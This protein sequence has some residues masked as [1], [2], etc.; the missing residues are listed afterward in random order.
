MFNDCWIY[1]RHERR[2]Y[3]DTVQ[4]CIYFFIDST[5]N[6]ETEKVVVV[7]SFAVWNE[8][9]MNI[10][11]K[12]TTDTFIGKTASGVVLGN[13]PEDHTHVTCRLQIQNWNAIPIS[14]LQA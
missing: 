8:H 13:I 1:L 6:A 4:N 11:M 14:R 2:L 9:G 3:K 10:G 7:Y 5:C 12:N